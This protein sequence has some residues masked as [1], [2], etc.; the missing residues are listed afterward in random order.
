V[1]AVVD[2]AL[3]KSVKLAIDAGLTTT[4]KEFHIPYKRVAKKHNAFF[5]LKN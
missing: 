4:G 3:T 5:L 1:V 2:Q